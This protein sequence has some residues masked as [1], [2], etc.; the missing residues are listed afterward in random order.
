MAV[1][2]PRAFLPAYAAPLRSAADASLPHTRRA[3]LP[4]LRYYDQ[5]TCIVH[6]IFGGETCEVVREAYGDAYLTAHFEVP[7]EMFTLA[8]EVGMGLCHATPHASACHAK[9]CH[10]MPRHAK[11]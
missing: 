4:R 8:M 3:L 5:G 1:T 11:P 9:P 7:G 10:A 2:P 6:H